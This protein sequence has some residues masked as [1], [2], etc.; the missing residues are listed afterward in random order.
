MKPSPSLLLAD[1]HAS[2]HDRRHHAGRAIFDYRLQISQSGEQQFQASRH[3]QGVA[4]APPVALEQLAWSAAAG[5][6]HAS[7]EQPHLQESASLQLQAGAAHTRLRSHRTGYREQERLLALPRPPVTLLSALFEIARHWPALRAG[8]PLQLAYAVLKVQAQ[9]GVTLRLQQQGG[10]S[11]VQLMPDNWFWRLLFGATVFHF[12]GD[13][14]RLTAIDGLLEPRDLNRRGKYIEYLGRVDFA[15]PL[16]L[17]FV[18]EV[19]HG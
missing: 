8:K 5:L 6:Q 4:G 18:R 15:A 16:D 3:W 10:H 19:A 13:K 14:P 2:V 12:A 11:V 1:V 7:Y 9:T 17:T